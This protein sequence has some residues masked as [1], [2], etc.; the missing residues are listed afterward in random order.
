LDAIFDDWRALLPLPDGDYSWQVRGVD[1]VGF[2][3]TNPGPWSAP[4]PFT[5]DTVA[6]DVTLTAPAS[7]LFGAAGVTVTGTVADENPGTVVLLDN[8]SV[9]ATD[10][11]GGS[12]FSFAYAPGTGVHTLEVVA[13]DRAGNSD[14][15]SRASVVVSIDA[16][17]P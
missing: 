11:S 6:P 13:T 16:D 7:G 1:R 3:L 2:D 9:V 12:S 5:V 14:A 8:G 17:A 4:V 15:G 10:S